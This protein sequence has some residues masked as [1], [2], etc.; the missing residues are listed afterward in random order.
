MCDGKEIGS[1]RVDKTVPGVFSFDDFLDI[2]QDAGEPVVN[3]YAKRGGVFTGTV[4]KVLIDIAPESHHDP[5]LV[6]RAKY[7]KQ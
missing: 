2:G 1:G 6:L 3:D 5:D 7:A 4:D